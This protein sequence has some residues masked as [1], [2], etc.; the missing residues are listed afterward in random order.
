MQQVHSLWSHKSFISESLY[1][2]SFQDDGL[3]YQRKLK[4]TICSEALRKLFGK[5]VPTIGNQ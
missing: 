5:L 3:S 4:G 1:M 2:Y